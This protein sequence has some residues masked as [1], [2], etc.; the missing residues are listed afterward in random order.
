MKERQPMTQSE[1]PSTA[2]AA[3]RSVPE[4]WP[5]SPAR[6]SLADKL[7]IAIFGSRKPKV[8]RQPQDRDGRDC[9][10]LRLYQF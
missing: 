8:D 4:R 1:R 2:T 9:A 5:T 6:L 10:P 7:I 3:D